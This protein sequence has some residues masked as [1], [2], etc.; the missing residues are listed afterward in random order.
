MPQIINIERPTTL[1]PFKIKEPIDFKNQAR[2]KEE[3]QY[4]PTSF[5]QSKGKGKVIMEVSEKEI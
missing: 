5:Q 3:N 2:N 4:P 1:P